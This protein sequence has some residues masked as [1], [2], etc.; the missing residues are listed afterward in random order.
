[1][2]SS[3]A[4]WEGSSE[5]GYIKDMVYNV[6]QRRSE[7]R[8]SRSFRKETLYKLL[9]KSYNVLLNGSSKTYL[10]AAVCIIICV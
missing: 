5:R 8:P 2:A 3:L 9:L 4:V 1:M 6:T 10:I 7:I